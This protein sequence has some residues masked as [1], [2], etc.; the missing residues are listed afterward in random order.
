MI[1]IK[2]STV[3]KIIMKTKIIANHDD[4]F[5]VL[6]ILTRSAII[7]VKF[8]ITIKAILAFS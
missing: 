3:G 7:D 5:T 1:A 2:N 8:I 4:F 6:H